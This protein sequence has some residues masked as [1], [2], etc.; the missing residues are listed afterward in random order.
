MNDNHKVIGSSPVEPIYN[1]CFRGEIGIRNSF[2]HYF[3]KVQ[4][5]SKVLFIKKNFINMFINSKVHVIYKF[6]DNTKFLLSFF[7]KKEN[8]WEELLKFNIYILVISLLN[9]YLIFNLFK[10]H[11]EILGLLLIL[12]V[13]IVYFIKKI[14]KLKIDLKKNILEK[15]AIYIRFFNF[16]LFDIILSLKMYLLNTKEE[17][18]NFYFLIKNMPLKLKV[19]MLIYYY[20]N[21]MS[22]NLFERGFE[23]RGFYNFYTYFNV[24]TYP[25][26]AGY[27]FDE[28]YKNFFYDNDIQSETDVF[29]LFDQGAKLQLNLPKQFFVYAYLFIAFYDKYKDDAH[30]LYIELGE[31]YSNVKYKCK[32]FPK[33]LINIFEFLVR[34]PIISKENILETKEVL[35]LFK[36]FHDYFNN[37]DNITKNWHRV[38]LHNRIFNTATNSIFEFIN[39]KDD[40]KK[41]NILEIKFLELLEI[42]LD[43]IKNLISYLNEAIIVFYLVSPRCR[44]TDNPIIEQKE[45]NQKIILNSFYINILCEMGALSYDLDDDLLDSNLTLYYISGHD[46]DRYIRV[47]DKVFTLKDFLNDI[48]FFYNAFFIQA[49]DFIT[50][51]FTCLISRLPL[52]TVLL[53]KINK[54]MLCFF[55]FGLFYY[56]ANNIDSLFLNKD[57]KE[58]LLVF[59]P[60]YVRLGK[61]DMLCVGKKIVKGGAEHINK[62]TEQFL[63]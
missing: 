57:I 2:R 48:K 24:I 45:K 11:I 27:V 10:N 14:Y 16:I 63:F 28:K 20:L 59:F 4:V 31:S 3:L 13:L 39:N 7:E 26:N 52:L 58:V 54:I 5:L 6:N 42:Q 33:D 18:R 60:T 61:D 1:I 22:T 44:K 56:F 36:A 38:D 41:N 8:F 55:F 25:K 40:Y 43:C 51:E 29:N 12:E 35:L 32:L 21:I 23:N 49:K 30:S 53:L 34:L 50:Q 47:Y 46:K 15:I 17:F 37:V 62:S 19:I 9:I